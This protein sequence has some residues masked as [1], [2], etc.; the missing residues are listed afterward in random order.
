MPRYAAV[1][2]FIFVF[3]CLVVC[4]VRIAVTLYH[5]HLFLVIMLK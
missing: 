3:I 5:N 1:M 4:N 2:L